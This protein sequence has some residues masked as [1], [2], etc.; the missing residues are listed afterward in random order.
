M[1]KPHLAVLPFRAIHQLLQPLQ[2]WEVIKPVIASEPNIAGVAPVVIAFGIRGEMH[3]SA[4][5][6]SGVGFID[7]G[8]KTTKMSSIGGP[9]LPLT[10]PVID[11]MQGAFGTVPEVFQHTINIPFVI[12]SH[13]SE[14]AGTG[15][16]DFRPIDPYRSFPSHAGLP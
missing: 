1:M 15:V 2:I 6:F 4:A 8:E 3:R 12:E 14:R 7:P 16:R 11:I 13:N 9:I 5:S 10:R